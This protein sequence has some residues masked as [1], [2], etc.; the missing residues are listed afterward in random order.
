VTYGGRHDC[1]RFQKH[2]SSFILLFTIA[3]IGLNRKIEENE[4]KYIKRLADTVAIKSVSAWPENRPDVKRMVEWTKAVWTT[5]YLISKI[6]MF[7]GQL[8]SDWT[9]YY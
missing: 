2:P 1:F 4:A 5:F 7:G 3:V 6:N 9:K 8:I